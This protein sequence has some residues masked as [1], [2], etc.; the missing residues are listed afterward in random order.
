LLFSGHVFI[1]IQQMLSSSCF[2]FLLHSVLHER[3]QL[4]QQEAAGLEVNIL[5]LQRD[6]E[7]AQQRQQR[8]DQSSAH[9]ASLLAAERSASRGALAKACSLQ[10]FGGV[11][12]GQCR[13]LQARSEAAAAANA[14]AQASAELAAGE[15]M[16]CQGRLQVAHETEQ[17]LRQQVA[18]L[19]V[20]K[21][22]L[23]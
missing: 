8:S 3:L 22:H 14:A 11:W 17:Q 19:E 6:L 5:W 9:T 7:S 23:C 16:A 18:C 13:Q 20:T 21:A 10:A 4:A 12:Q 1:V 2:G 15:L